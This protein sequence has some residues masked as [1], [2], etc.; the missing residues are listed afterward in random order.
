MI[1]DSFLEN[2]LFSL[3]PLTAYDIVSSIGVSLLILV[4]GMLL[5]YYWWIKTTDFYFPKGSAS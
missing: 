2:R 5:F 1:V 4:C 3:V